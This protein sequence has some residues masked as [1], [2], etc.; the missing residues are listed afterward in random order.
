M[1]PRCFLDLGP[2]FAECQ[3]VLPTL[4]HV[5][6]ASWSLQAKGKKIARLVGFVCLHTSMG[7]NW[8]TAATGGQSQGPFLCGPIKISA[9]LGLKGITRWRFLAKSCPW[10]DSDNPADVM[11]GSVASAGHF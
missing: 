5:M 2:D 11:G 9:Q 1:G 10:L 8:G 7:L 4:S 3:G 6:V